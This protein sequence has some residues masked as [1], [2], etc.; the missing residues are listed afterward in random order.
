M[1]EF[2]VY[3]EDIIEAIDFIEEYTKD[4]TYEFYF[5]QERLV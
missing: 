1:R 3:L 2:Q 5:C 4:L